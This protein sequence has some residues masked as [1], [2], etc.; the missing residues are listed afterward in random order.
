MLTEAEVQAPLVGGGPGIG[1]L[2]VLRSRDDRGGKYLEPETKAGIRAIPALR[3]AAR[4]WQRLQDGHHPDTVGVTYGHKIR[5]Y[6]RHP[7]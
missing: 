4:G 5:R 6:C 1:N 2:L 7:P 3:V